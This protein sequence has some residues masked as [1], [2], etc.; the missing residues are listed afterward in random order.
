MYQQF[1]RQL[2]GSNLEKPV[3]LLNGSIMVA[4]PFLIGLTNSS[5]KSCMTLNTVN[6]L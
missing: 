5:I 3:E 4:M 1:N 6:V 2:S